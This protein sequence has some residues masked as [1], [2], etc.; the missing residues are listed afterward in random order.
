VFCA[1]PMFLWRISNHVGLDGRGG[2]L[3]SARWHTQGRPIV[4]L[5]GS[6]PGALVEVL[7]NLELDP[8]R[9]PGSYTL[10]KAEAPDEFPVG[11]VEVGALPE[12]WVGNLAVTRGVGDKWLASGES[13][14][15]EVPSAILPETSNWLLNPLH[16]DAGRVRVVWTQAHPYDRRFF[17]VRR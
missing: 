11:R 12:G 9:L 14:L 1:C 3:A 6:P 10:L 8:A 15:L 13:A 4:Y 7:V 2:L 5:A 17:R 16:A